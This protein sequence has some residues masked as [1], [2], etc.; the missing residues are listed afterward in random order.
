M[1]DFFP[2][3]VGCWYFCDDDDLGPSLFEWE[4]SVG[5]GGDEP[6]PTRTRIHGK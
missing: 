6:H 2:I 5:D 4:A 1:V 3:V